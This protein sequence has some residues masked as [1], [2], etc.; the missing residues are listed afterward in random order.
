VSAIIIIVAIPCTTV[1]HPLTAVPAH[2]PLPLTDTRRRSRGYDKCLTLEVALLPISVQGPL[3]FSNSSNKG[4]H[5]PL[6][7]RAHW[8]KVVHRPPLE[9]RQDQRQLLTSRTED[10]RGRGMEVWTVRG[11]GS[12]A[13]EDPLTLAMGAGHPAPVEK[14][15]G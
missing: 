12:K 6:P 7:P 8:V 2:V 11:S 15:L 10:T 5:L 9:P 3:V 13:Q 1:D 14:E 4:H